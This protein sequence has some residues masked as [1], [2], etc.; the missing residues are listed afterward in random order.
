MPDELETLLRTHAAVRDPDPAHARTLYRAARRRSRLERL[1]AGGALALVVFAVAVLGAALVGRDEEGG[2][3][4]TNPDTETSTPTTSL[5]DDPTVSWRE[6]DTGG[7]VQIP[8]GVALAGSASHLLIWGGEDA[9][10]VA[11]RNDGTLVDLTSEQTRA[12]SPA[13]TGPRRGA[14]ARAFNEEFLVVGGADVDELFTDGAIYDPRTDAWREVGPAPLGRPFGLLIDAEVVGDKALALFQSSQTG[15]VPDFS[16]EGWELCALELPGGDWTGCRD[17]P[18]PDGSGLRPARAV[19]AANADEAILLVDHGFN[20]DRGVVV[21]T[22]IIDP[23]ELTLAPRGEMA[24]PP[25]PTS[26]VD[27]L[28]GGVLLPDGN[29]VAWGFQQTAA[30]DSVGVQLPFPSAECIQTGAGIGEVTIIASC[31]PPAALLTDR[32][33]VSIALP[34]GGRI[35]QAGPDRVVLVSP[36]I[37]EG[38]IWITNTTERD[39]PT[40]REAASGESLAEVLE[41]PLGSD[42]RSLSYPTNLGPITRK[43][44]FLNLVA[45]DGYTGFGASITDAPI[46][47]LLEDLCTDRPCEATPETSPG[48]DLREWRYVGVGGSPGIVSLTEGAWTVLIESPD[49]ERARSLAEGLRIAQGAGGPRV[50]VDAPE[51]SPRQGPQIVQLRFGA[52]SQF[53]GTEPALVVTT[54]C[55][56]RDEDFGPGVCSDAGLLTNLTAAS[57]SVQ[58]DLSELNL[59][60]VP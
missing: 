19:L 48:G 41:F 36:A 26:V 8:Q 12:T 25:S 37:G 50:V 39:G 5:G 27:S 43:T 9:Q 31:G 7:P 15:G 38:M 54:E 29:L 53:R 24:I 6:L 28:S 18:V 40:A 46:E 16:S 2:Q 47:T 42:R 60:V 34:G 49:T 55:P 58:I 23:E 57:E 32:G 1:L 21:E 22:S 4:T 35:L 11:A 14:I 30:D 52:T 20:R 10:G 59:Q 44:Y 17:A 13:P 3:V 56:V 33:L 45:A 51:W